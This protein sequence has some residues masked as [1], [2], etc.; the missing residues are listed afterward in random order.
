VR[1]SGILQRARLFGGRFCCAV[2]CCIG[3]QHAS[4]IGHGCAGIECHGDTKGLGHFFA[5]CTGIDGA[6]GMHADAA[7][8]AR[9]DGDGDGDGDKLAGLGFEMDGLAGALVECE[10]AGSGV[11]RQNR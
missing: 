5:G 2:D 1:S 7:V 3:I 4:R 10:E 8:A 11:R 6:L 9:G